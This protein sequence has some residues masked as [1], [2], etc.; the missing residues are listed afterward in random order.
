MTKWTSFPHDNSAFKYEG[1]SLFEA[2]PD[3]HR[4]D[5]VEYPDAD[6]VQECL[7]EVPE[8][9]PESYDDDA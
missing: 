8:S 9:A 4:G 1:N 5:C 3:L 7:E 2:W 6:W